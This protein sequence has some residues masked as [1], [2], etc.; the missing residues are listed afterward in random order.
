MPK[1]KT[2][3]M[4]SIHRRDFLRVIGAGATALAAP[5][6]ASAADAPK[7]RP[8][9]LF[10]LAD[11]LGWRDTSLY[12]S[13]FYE[14]PNVDRLAARG[15]RFTQAYA[16]NP[17]CS[18]TRASLQTGL[19]PCRIGITAP[20]CHVPQEVLQESLQKAAPPHQKALACQSATRLKQDYFT[21][22]EAFKEA[23][24]AT[25]HF[26][27][28]H[29]GPEPYDPLHQ[30]Y[31]VDVPHWPGPGPAGSY[32]APWRF[33][34]KLAFQGQP[35]E[36]IEDRMGA[37]VVKF[38]REH[39]DHPFFATY[40]CFSVH[41]PF[42]AKKALMEKYRAK[43]DPRNPQRHPV[44]G[45]MVQ[46]MDENVGRVVQ[47]LDDLGLA[48]NTAIV[49]FS[50]NGGVHWPGNKGEGNETNCPITSNLPL[51]GGKAT[52]YEGGTREPCIVVWPS[53][54]T[55]GSQSDAIIQS[56]DFYPTLLEMAGLKPREGLRL[57]GISIVPALRGLPLGRDAIFCHF[58]HYVKATGNLPGTYVRK[59]D[60]KLIRFYADN[61]DHSDRFELYNL[62]DDLGETTDLAAKMPEKV[63]EL[64]ALI[65]EHL[66]DT[67]AVVPAPNP[68]YRRGALEGAPGAGDGSGGWR[69]IGTCTLAA[70]PGLLAVTSTGGDPIVL[71]QDVPAWTGPLVVRV[72][73]RCATGG[74]GQLFWST[75][76]VRPFHR[77]RSVVFPLQ[78]DGAWHDY[79]VKAPIEGKLEALRL[80]PGTA[81]GEIEIDWIR[82]LKADGTALKSWEF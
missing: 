5:R 62:K 45:A 52:L 63:R 47:A 28:W 61:D 51:R 75:A 79:E 80:D 77:S 22:A 56:I 74:P 2:V 82:L 40:W 39:K 8:N 36:H 43:A 7:K 33:P 72:R 46:S 81:P 69:A 1:G 35:G 70:K 59:G 11:D 38:L 68:A 14:T 60:W 73:M 66:K 6:L 17:L 44:M 53:V 25:G 67:A 42:D 21:L 30:G 27:K 37:E 12:G 23:G 19:Y 34:P 71:T 4:Q 41:S 55:P 18:P 48:E 76:Q 64:N 54:V 13:T 26:G 57:D 16:A 29:L 49:F 58:P 32:V 24:Y 10:I 50:D 9:V 3:P 65:E 78:H 20:V 31:D 15:M